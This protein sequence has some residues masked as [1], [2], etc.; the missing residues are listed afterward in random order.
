MS[1]DEVVTV[2]AATVA[3]AGTIGRHRAAM[4]RD[5]AR[6][7]GPAAEAALAEATADYLAEAIPAGVYAGWLALAPDGAVV[8]GAGV[9]VRPIVPRPGPVGGV[10]TA[11]QAL[12]LNV[13][14]EPAWRR[15][16]IA[17]RLVRAA[18]D[19]A[20]ARGVSGV[21]LHASDAGRALYERL[22][23]LPTNEMAYHGAPVVP[24]TRIRST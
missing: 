24:L 13:Y 11:P 22:G 3:D 5:M 18:L 19:W 10:L 16:G 7:A 12:L 2:R 4:F 14:T 8:G 17:E 20:D 21:V 1:G 9:Q 23:F 15:R 6:T